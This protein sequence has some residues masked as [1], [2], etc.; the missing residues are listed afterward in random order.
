MPFPTVRTGALGLALATAVSFALTR[1]IR[2][3]PLAAAGLEAPVD[4]AANLEAAAPATPVSGL[5]PA[6]RIVSF[7]GNPR[8]AR[9]GILGE[10]P[11]D[12]LL[13]RLR[14]QAAAYAAADPGTPV[15]PALH[16][17][18]VV[19]QKDAGADGLHRGR[20]PAALVD[21]VASWIDP[22][23]MLLF[24][25]IQPG[26]SSMVAEARNYIAFLERPWVHLALDPEFAVARGIVPGSRI[27]GIDA[28]DV[29]AVI[30]LLAG[31]VERLGLPP[32]ILIVHRFTERMLTGA[33]RIR[34]NP[35][36][37]V[38]IT[39]DGFG[40]PELKE[41]AYRCVIAAQPVEYTGFKLFYR[42]DAPLMSP[43]RVLALRPA[44]HVIIYQ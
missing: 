26:G 35:R 6:H 24:L 34:L 15:I 42:Q 22:D 12:T 20:M 2:E 7:Y 36:V 39:M 18:T 10:L 23:S 28:E 37:Q 29:N 16:L 11:P 38:V 8:S 25:D 40:G 41:D 19:A 5:L 13:H 44:P 4:C 14:A 30:D 31:L 27:G 33:A 32:K 43:T 1:M 17:V 9:M 21:E 3:A